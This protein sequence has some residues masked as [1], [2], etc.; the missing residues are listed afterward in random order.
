MPAQNPMS[1]TR[2][3]PFVGDTIGEDTIVINIE[4]GSYYSLTPSG[5]QVW[6]LSGPAPAE[7]P[8]ELQPSAW[9]LVSEGIITLAEGSGKISDSGA[10]EPAFTKYTDMSD[11]LLADPIHDVDDEG[12]P[13]LR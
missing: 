13:K 1:V 10:A 12:W 4:T 7:V 5:G 2:A 8:A 6:A 9:S 3:K 11:I